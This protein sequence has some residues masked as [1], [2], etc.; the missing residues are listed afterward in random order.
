MR[1]LFSFAGGSGHFLPMTVFAKALAHKG[2]EVRNACQE[3]M[4]ASVEAA[5]WHAEPT[6]GASLISPADRRPLIAVDR[7]RDEGAISKAFAGKIARERAQRLGEL[8]GRWCPDTVVRDDVDFGAAITAEV[9]GL[10]H[11][12]IVV[13]AAGRLTRPEVIEGPLS[14]L[15][16]G[17]GFGSASTKAK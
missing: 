11:A 6:G 15:P 7:D 2:H 1:F 8:M 14:S 10:P 3:G 12:S 4:V 17:L 16:A 9:A 13:I 5:G